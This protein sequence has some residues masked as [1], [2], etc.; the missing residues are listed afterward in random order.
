[1]LYDYKWSSLQLPHIYMHTKTLQL[2]WVLYVPCG[3]FMDIPTHPDTS[4]A[5]KTQLPVVYNY[6][7]LLHTNMYSVP[8]MQH[9]N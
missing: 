9:V 6:Y 1:M 3:S 4:V 8:K 7:V 2:P 5:S